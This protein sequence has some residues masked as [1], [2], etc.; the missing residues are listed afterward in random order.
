MK[1]YIEKY[2]EEILKT[3]LLSTDDIITKVVDVSTIRAYRDNKIYQPLSMYKVWAQDSLIKVDEKKQL[4]FKEN[5]FEKIHCYFSEDLQ[6]FWKKNDGTELDK[7]YKVYKIVDLFF[8]GITL[9][10]ELNKKRREFFFENVHSP[11]DQYSMKLLKNYSDSLKKEIPNNVSMSLIQNDKEKY[12]RFQEEIKRIS[13]EFNITSYI[14]D[15][16]AWR[17]GHIETKK[18][19]EYKLIKKI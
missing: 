6:N 18:E 1:Q 7:I 4:I 11:L 8:K 9:W 16:I 17:V 12:I 2:K 15:E 3:G 5:D 19:G 10:E 14:F 13:N